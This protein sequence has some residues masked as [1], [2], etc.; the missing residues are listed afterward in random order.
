MWRVCSP[1]RREE[2]G[3]VTGGERRILLVA[4][5]E[6]RVK[7]VLNGSGARQKGGNRASSTEQSRSNHRC[8]TDGDGA[9]GRFADSR[10]AG[11]PRLRFLV[12]L[13]SNGGGQV[14]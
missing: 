13:V 14:A 5:E 7:V 12:S 10:C 8:S 9:G 6:S 4:R 2:E 3:R 1:E 11:G